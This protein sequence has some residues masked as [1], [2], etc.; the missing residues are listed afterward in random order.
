MLFGQRHAIDVARNTLAAGARRTVI[1]VA[2]GRPMPPSSG[3]PDHTG[4][5]RTAGH[6]RAERRRR[7]VPYPLGTAFDVIIETARARPARSPS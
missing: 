5:P 6:G 7:A 2:I 3:P 1:E 4:D